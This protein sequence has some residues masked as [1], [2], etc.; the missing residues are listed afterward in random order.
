MD[1]NPTP[2]VLQGCHLSRARMESKMCA[3]WGSDL[4]PEA[5][6]VSS[7]CGPISLQLFGWHPCP[8]N[9]N[10]H[11]G[12]A[13]ND[14]RP[15]RPIEEPAGGHGQQGQ[16]GGH[17]EGKGLQAD[18]DQ[19]SEDGEPV[20]CQGERGS[21]TAGGVARATQGPLPQEGRTD[22]LCGPWVPETSLKPKQGLIWGP[23]E[24]PGGPFCPS[25]LP[26]GP[27]H[28]SKLLLVPCV[29]SFGSG[30]MGLWSYRL[31]PNVTVSDSSIPLESPSLSKQAFQS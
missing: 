29:S 2:C 25:A 23:S 7:R 1:V 28:S 4:D 19:V 3:G 30:L 27:V 21:E 14:K 6:A 16:R 24:H 22:V 18:V 31:L 15:Q 8:S 12:Q 10:G 17:A 20:H 11:Q 9:D 13:A 26:G 5:Q